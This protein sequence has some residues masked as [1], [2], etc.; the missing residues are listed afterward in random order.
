M[1]DDDDFDIFAKID[2]IV[3]QHQLT[4][5][6]DKRNVSPQSAEKLHQP[7]ERNFAEKS[8]WQQPAHGSQPPSGLV[9]QSHHGP[10]HGQQQGHRW[11][12][13]AG[14]E[15]RIYSIQRG[16]QN[17][18]SSA[19]NNVF[20]NALPSSG[21]PALQRPPK[22]APHAR[23]PH[24]SWQPQQPQPTGQATAARASG[25]A[26]H[27][28]TTRP[29]HAG[30][31]GPGRPGMA[32]SVARPASTQGVAPHGVTRGPIAVVGRGGTVQGLPAAASA[33][34]PAGMPHQRPTSAGFGAGYARGQP[35]AK[36]AAAQPR[37][38]ELQSPVRGA[39][40][41]SAA[42]S[43]PQP[44]N[45][46]VA[47]QLAGA[48]ETLPELTLATTLDRLQRE[49]D[50]L[51]R[52]LNDNEGQN[53]LLRARV[54]RAERERRDVQTRI[55]QASQGG[56]TAATLADTQRKLD[57]A[58]KELAF[59]E[60]EAAEVQR[61]NADRDARLKAADAQAAAL[62]AEAKRLEQQRAQLEAEL[63]EA[64]RERRER[65]A[66][67]STS[68][69][70]NAEALRSPGAG[71]RS[72]S[73]RNWQQQQ[74]Q[75]PSAAARKAAAAAAGSAAGAARSATASAGQ[76]RRLSGA[77]AAAGP[78]SHS[79]ER[80]GPGSVARSSQPPSNMGI[81]S[82]PAEPIHERTTWHSV[83]SP[84]G[85]GSLWQSL[86]VACGA[87]LAVLLAER[88]G[89]GTSPGSTAEEVAR[90]ARLLAWGV[91]SAGPALL[92]ALCSALA[93]DCERT[94]DQASQLDVRWQCAMLDVLSALLRLCGSCQA[95]ALASLA[96]SGQLPAA[97][98]LPPT[99]L[100]PRVQ[101]QMP[102]NTAD[103]PEVAASSGALGLHAMMLVDSAPPS[104]SLASLL[105]HLRGLRL[106][107]LEACGR[108]VL[109][110]LLDTLLRTDAACASFACAL[111][112]VAALAAAA[113]PLDRGIMSLIL[114]SG[115]LEK[116]ASHKMAFLQILHLLLEC[117]AICDLLEASL[118]P[119]AAQGEDADAQP[120]TGTA[121]AEAGVE[122]NPQE[123]G[124]TDGLTKSWSGCWNIFQALNNCLSAVPAA[125]KATDDCPYQ[126]PRR[127][128]LV[129]AL[130]ME[131][132]RYGL[133][134]P[135]LSEE[136][137]SPSLV[138]RLVILVDDVTRSPTGG[139]LQALAA[140]P[141]PATAPEAR[142]WQVALRV[143]QEAL[144]L[145]RGLS[146]AEHLR[147][148]V[149]EEHLASPA[150]T[151]LCHVV[152]GRIVQLRPLPPRL[153]RSAPPLPLAPWAHAVGASSVTRSVCVS[154]DSADGPPGCLP[155]ATVEDVMHL[156][157]GL[158]R[159]V[160]ERLPVLMQ[161]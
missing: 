8:S 59:K 161:P 84:S 155:V 86:S 49:R 130:C 125:A 12:Q 109:G 110:V 10:T 81:Q 39:P 20:G 46:L 41:A 80:S 11:N 112:A 145:L 47:A 26:S 160:Q 97:Q 77:A 6:S 61:R 23:Q 76:K 134:L 31:T 87:S 92:C 152:V 34:A 79:G 117:P 53:A 15:P 82:I 35:P 42:P 3:E 33:A 137:G 29:P 138:Q 100:G 50:E 108:G 113:L 58:L 101:L 22:G 103:A 78:G 89:E 93:A 73:P 40:G 128:L 25:L 64:H 66:D 136:A 153:L 9:H 38:L 146:A 52:R 48:E 120:I 159:R 17:G 143:V 91:D 63:A 150:A 90:Q 156:A 107:D 104:D 131:A 111:H 65:A 102:A 54:E 72:L 60:Q 123:R 56:L 75:P 74:Q 114:T 140:Q 16:P 67:A 141:R 98:A 157:K 45:L 158:L 154:A 36:S 4:K 88:G 7:A 70:G 139:P 147:E 132:G 116:A 118:A 28:P 149:L 2:S 135:L 83:A 127:A 44:T 37:P 124:G 106:G 5:V 119:Q 126:V 99:G 24:A 27:A 142:R 14:A 69:G 18:Y 68:G 62:A 148:L 32:V 85:T 129:L 1:D 30:G 151:R 115:V 51:Q 19:P 57:T 21:A 71:R 133:L 13:A 121:D 96:P 55:S 144:T 105:N 122:G 95:L 43:S 94:N